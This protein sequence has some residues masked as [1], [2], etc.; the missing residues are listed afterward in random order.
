MK[1]LLFAALTLC[2]IAF[3]SCGD[4]CSL[5]D[6]T[7]DAAA[8][9][10]LGQTYF[11]DSTLESCNAYSDALTAFINDYKDCEDAAIV[12]QVTATQAALDALD[13]Q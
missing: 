6:A 8:Y 1:N 10:T 13:C 11:A 9:S 2:T 12:T 7:S 3:Y 4:S 5:T